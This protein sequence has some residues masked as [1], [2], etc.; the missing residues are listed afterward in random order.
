MKR[1]TN[2][3]KVFDAVNTAVLLLIF[4]AVAYPLYYLL[5][6]SLS[7]PEA[8]RT[9]K[10]LLFPE[11]LYLEG[12]RRCLQY[13]RLWTGYRNTFL[14]AIGG[15]ALAAAVTLPTAYALS[16]KDMSLRTPIM[17]LFSFTM[18]FSGGMIPNYLLMKNLGI[19]DT[20]WVMLLPGCVSIWNVIICRS[21]FSA[22]IDDA[23][24]DAARI[25]GCNDFH[26]FFSIVLPVSKTILAVMLLFYASSKWNA[27]FDAMIYL[28]NQNLFPLQ[29]ILKGLLH[30]VDASQMI[31]DAETT[32]QLER[33]VDQLK[34]CIIIISIAPMMLFYPFVQ[35]YF[36]K[37][38]MVGSLK[39]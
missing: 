21:F 10:A 32:A 20:V 28:R 15:S 39:G 19:Y 13:A 36:I 26:F 9:G 22:N 38:V 33:L 29:L 4:I 6:A 37:G 1:K 24:L 27:Y 11:G 3:D 14:Y 2:S 8:V 25:D 5:A 18:F 35:K 17:L 30:S 23:L 31:E 34:Y 7:E 12:Y 16:R